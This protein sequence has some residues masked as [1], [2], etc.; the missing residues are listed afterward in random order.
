MPCITA[1]VLSFSFVEIIEQL[2]IAQAHPPLK[3]CG[4]F[5][6]PVAVSIYAS[7]YVGNAVAYKL[8]D[9]LAVEETARY[10]A[11]LVVL[12]GVVWSKNLYGRRIVSFVKMLHAFGAVYVH[13]EWRLKRRNGLP[14]LDG[15]LSGCNQ[16]APFRANA[17]QYRLHIILS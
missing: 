13:L 17:Y 11:R 15:L 7:C 4:I 2:I 9:N 14:H 1:V 10:E 6:V 5:K 12:F 8:T 3:E 16:F